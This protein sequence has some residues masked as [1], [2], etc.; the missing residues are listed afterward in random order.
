VRSEGRCALIKGVGSDVHERLYRPE[1]K[2][3]RIKQLHTLTVLH[4]NH[5]LTTE[6]SETTTHFNGNFDIDNQIYI[7]YPKVHSDFPNALYSLD[8]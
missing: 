7:P 8:H 3:N 5:C 2:L 4:F 6:C 1:T